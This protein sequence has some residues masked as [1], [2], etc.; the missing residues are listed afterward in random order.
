MKIAIYQCKGVPG[1]KENNL[2]LLS[3]VAQSASE[4]GGTVVDLPGDV[5]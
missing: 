2:K 4:Q 5:S 1:S 3:E